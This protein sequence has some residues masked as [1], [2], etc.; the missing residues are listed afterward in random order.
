MIKDNREKKVNQRLVS[1]PVSQLMFV[2]L[3]SIT[4]SS[5]FDCPRDWILEMHDLELI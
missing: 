4:T 2:R 5:A 3:S 1:L